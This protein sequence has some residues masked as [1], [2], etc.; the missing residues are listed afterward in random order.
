MKSINL[1]LLALIVLTSLYSC[2]DVLNDL[3][4]AEIAQKLEGNWECNE[5]SSLY[6]STEDIYYVYISPSNADTNR[7]DISNF[8]GL[9]S[10]V[11]A[12]ATISDYSISIPTQTLEGGFEIKGSGTIAS[13]LKTISLKYYVDD[14]SGEVDEVEALYTY[15][16]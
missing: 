3:T 10:G 2:E 15:K 5:T 7:I 6:K 13:N 14:G 8:Y 1:F 16:Y 12:T 4:T 11:D 9:G